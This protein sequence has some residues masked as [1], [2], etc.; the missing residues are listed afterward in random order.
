MNVNRCIFL[1]RTIPH[2]HSF[3]TAFAFCATCGGSHENAA[4][5]L[6]PSETVGVLR[7]GVEADMLCI[8]SPGGR[9]TTSACKGTDSV[10][11]RSDLIGQF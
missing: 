8:C 11:A 10:G 9:R 4:A 1:K 3:S 2:L 7:C 5:I 6:I